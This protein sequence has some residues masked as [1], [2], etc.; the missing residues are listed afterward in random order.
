MMI[1]E[2]KGTGVV[3]Y[4]QQEGRGI[5]LTNKIRAYQ[6][7]DQGMDTYDAN[8]HLGFQPDER[9]YELSAAMIQKL[10]VK[11]VRLLT[12]NPE[13]VSGLEKYNITVTEQVPLVLPANVHNRRYMET[14]RDRFG[15]DINVA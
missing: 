14:K 8:I 15:H 5:G 12:N 7:Q 13:K 6:L 3:I 4:M 9:D 11:S 2:E 10:G 1:I